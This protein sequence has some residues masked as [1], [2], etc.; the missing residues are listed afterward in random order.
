MFKKEKMSSK[1][2][3]SVCCLVIV[4]VGL[5][6]LAGCGEKKDIFVTV[7]GTEITLDQVD[8][9]AAFVALQYGMDYSTLDAALK[10]NLET[11]MLSYLV[12]DRLIKAYF[13]SKDITVITDEIKKLV[14]EQIA[15]ALETP[16]VQKQL[17]DNHISEDT[18]R[19]VFEAQFYNQEYQKQVNLDTPVSDKE[20]S[21]YYDEH[22]AEF[23]TPSSISVSQIMMG[24][25]THDE[26]VRAQIEEVRQRILDG[27]DFA[28]LANEFSIDPASNTVGGNMGSIT[29]GVWGTAFDDVAFSLTNGA[30]SEVVESEYGFHI[31]LATGDVIEEQAQSLEQAKTTISNILQTSHFEEA[32]TQLRKDAKIKFDEDRVEYNAETGIISVKATTE[33][34]ISK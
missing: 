2:F 23:V 3:V 27:E 12:E 17:E 5:F 14:D 16:D 20:I 33:A 8:Q 1:I 25:S 34:A 4:F 31:I 22:K 19:I 24:D 32:L 28:A 21:E 29:K 7:D 26:A 10:A 15:N 11:S 30:L 6:S 18:L 13:E 9:M